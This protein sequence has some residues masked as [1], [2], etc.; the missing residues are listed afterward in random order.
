[1][2]GINEQLNATRF[3][4]DR[5]Y[6]VIFHVQYRLDPLWLVDLSDP[7]HPAITG[8]LEVP[9]WSTFLQPLGNRLLALG[10]ETNRTTVSLFDVADPAH[11]GLL[12]RVPVGTGWSW[13]EANWDEHAFGVFPD[14]NLILVPFQSW[15]GTQSVQQVQLV[16][17]FADSLAA[18]GVIEH[19]FQ[20]RR[21]TIYGDRILSV[22]G[23]EQLSVKFS[24]R[25][26]VTF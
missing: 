4:G 15:T 6:V 5:A 3:D 7:A 21:A 24:N 25:A 16:D 12:S 14:A 20:P 22:S 11:P 8:Q 17:L 13:T 19:Q 1:M 18:R 23:Q 9:G 26:P 2:L 10:I